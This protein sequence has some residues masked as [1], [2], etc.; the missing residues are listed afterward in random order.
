M[1][2]KISDFSLQ[3]VMF[4]EAETSIPGIRAEYLIGS[5]K[6]Q[7]HLFP[8]DESAG[9]AEDTESSL[10]KAFAS[11]DDSNKVIDYV[12]EVTS[13]YV[14]LKGFGLNAMMVEHLLGRLAKEVG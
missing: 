13:W 10:K 7:F 11:F 8:S 4:T 6:V 5:G 2:D 3:P 14:E 1:F 9:F 12:P